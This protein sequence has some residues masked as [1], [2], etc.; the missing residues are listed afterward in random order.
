MA[1]SR[2]TGTRWTVAWWTG[3]D[4]RIRISVPAWGMTATRRQAVARA[5]RAVQGSAD[6]LASP[7]VRTTGWRPGLDDPHH[8]MGDDLMVGAGPGR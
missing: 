3:A 6:G 2:S 7:L 8:P 4:R 1:A 5:S